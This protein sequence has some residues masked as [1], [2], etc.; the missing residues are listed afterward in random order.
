MATALIFDL[1][2]MGKP[3]E[4]S[5]SLIKAHVGAC[6]AIARRWLLSATSAFG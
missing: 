2:D 4:H 1:M 6:P 3:P 5:N